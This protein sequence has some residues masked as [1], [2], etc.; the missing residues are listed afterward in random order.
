MHIFFL[1]LNEVFRFF[2]LP[3][4]WFIPQSVIITIMWLFNWRIS[5]LCLRNKIEVAEV[6]RDNYVFMGGWWMVGIW[7]YVLLQLYLCV[8]VWVHVCMHA[9]VCVCARAYLH[10]CGWVFACVCFDMGVG[11]YGGD[12]EHLSCHVTHAAV[13]CLL[14]TFRM[15]SSNDAGRGQDACGGMAGAD[16]V[17]VCVSWWPALNSPKNK[18]TSVL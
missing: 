12:L 13:C 16:P 1:H 3:N 15:T 2:I 14:G 18:D 17:C 10:V 7:A 4:S 11:G 5:Y 9:C 6:A 8:C